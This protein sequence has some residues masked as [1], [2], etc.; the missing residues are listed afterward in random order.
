MPKW[1]TRRPGTRLLGRSGRWE[2]VVPV[3]L[4]GGARFPQIGEL[5]YLLTLSG[6]GFYWF[7]LPS[8]AR[9]DAGGGPA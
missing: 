3:E 1:S 2:G 9:I 5:P 4:L 8:T 6:Y 7:R